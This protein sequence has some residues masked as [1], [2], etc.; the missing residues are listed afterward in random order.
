M[1]RGLLPPLSCDTA[2]RAHRVGRHQMLAVYRGKM[3]AQRA[4]L[5]QARAVLAGGAGSVDGVDG[6]RA[7]SL[8]DA[9][10]LVP[11][12]ASVGAPTVP[13]A[14]FDNGELAVLFDRRTRTACWSCERL[15]RR[16]AAA[17]SQPSGDRARS[18]FHSPPGEDALFAPTNDDYLHSGYDRGHLAPAADFKSQQAMDSSF[19]LANIAPQGTKAK[20]NQANQQ[21]KTLSSFFFFCA[22]VSRKIRALLL[23]VFFCLFF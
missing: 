18:V 2:V 7:T 8:A 13:T 14:L 15:Q 3:A 23:F 1:L 5:A 9:V 20:Q 19:S 21:T 6:N 11:A 16:A 12:L 17:A 4:E 22:C 10:P